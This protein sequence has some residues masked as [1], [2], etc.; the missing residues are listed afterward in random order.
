MHD[1]KCFKLHAGL[2]TARSDCPTVYFNSWSGTFHKI[3]QVTN[4]NKCPCAAG[5]WHST[6]QHVTHGE[7]V[8]PM[9]FTNILASIR[10]AWDMTMAPT[11][12]RVANRLQQGT[13]SKGHFNIETVKACIW[14]V[15]FSLSIC[16]S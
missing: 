14:C 6:R 13:C 8:K 7:S 16:T 4:D 10:S 9:I 5:D 11:F 1:S 3:L 12:L 2:I 15:M